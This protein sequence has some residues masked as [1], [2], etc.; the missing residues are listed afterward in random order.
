MTNILI[1]GTSRGIGLEM[2]RQSAQRGWR[3]FA[4]CRNPTDANELHDLAASS[5]GK[6]SVHPLDMNNFEQI[7]ALAKTIEEP[8]DIL[9]NNAGR[10]GSMQQRFNDV[11]VDDW[12]KTF[13]VNTIAPYQM[14]EAFIEHL[15]RGERKLIATLTSKMG[16]IDDNGSGS[17][18]IY[19]S[20]K[21]ALNAVV[22]SLSID[23]KS[24]GITCTLHHPGWVK[25][26]M[27]GP[28]AEI[29]TAESVAKMFAIMDRV[30][31]KNSGRFFD[32]DGSVIP[33]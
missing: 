14:V 25:T 28:N 7:Q 12:I 1:S 6:V 26:E 13:R 11:D 29:S 20:S 5:A 2:V 4:C 10:Y 19:R 15:E 32:I 24:R 17:C 30:T 8:I 18:Y 3:V 22:K 27:G 16:S 23:L 33:W 9:V 31:I 21:T